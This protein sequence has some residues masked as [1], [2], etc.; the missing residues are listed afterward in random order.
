MAER[1]DTSLKDLEKEI[2]CAIC[3]E[4]YTDPK[5]LSCCHYYCKQCILSL[6]KRTG[7][8]KPFSCPECRKDTALPQGGIDKFQG[9]FFV[10]RL[11]QVH[12]N[13]ELATGEVEANCEI[14]FEDKATAFCRQCA[15]F[16]CAECV[17]SHKRMK[18]IFPDHK[19]TTLEALKEGGAKEIVTPEPTFQT[20]QMHEEM[21]KLFCFDCGCLICRDCTI[22]D[23]HGHNYEF[24][25]KAAPEVKKNLSQ[26]LV[27][28]KE[29]KKDLLSAVK[30]VQTAKFK[31]EATEQSM[32]GGVEKWCDELCQIIQ[33]HKN[34]LIAEVKSN[35]TQKSGRLICQ[36]ERLSI[37]CA[38]SDSVIEFTQHSM[39]HSTDAEIVCVYAELKSR[40]D[41]EIEEHRQKNL[42]P[43]EKDDVALEVGGTE[44]LEKLCQTTAR[45]TFLKPPAQVEPLYDIYM[46]PMQRPAHDNMS[47]GP[48]QQV[49]RLPDNMPTSPVQRV[50]HSP[51]NMPTSPVQRVA[52]SPDN[53][54]TS[55]VQR[56]AHSPDNM[57]T[58]PVQRVAHSPDNMSTSPVQRVAHSP[59]NM[60]TGPVQRV[61][62]SPNIMSTGPVQR[63]AHSPDNMPTSPVQRVAHLPDNMPTG[64]VQR[65]AHSS[66]NMPTSPVQRVAHSSDN[67]PT[68]PVQR[69][70]HSP[71]NMSTG[72]VQRV[73]HL[74]DNMSTGP[75]QRV[76]HLPDN[77][78]TGPVQ[79]VA[80]LPD[81]MPTNPVQRVARLPDNM[82]TNPVQRVAHLPDNMPTSPVQRVAHL[83][84]NMS[85]DPLQQLIH[86]W[87][88]VKK[89]KS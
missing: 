2:T 46:L 78:S 12:S 69:V 42:E 53:M 56:V 55:P 76:A 45:I 8:D 11:K 38:V 50:A 17:K 36:E 65:V 34:G 29:V 22:K 82:P 75:V 23:H 57:S 74:P 54:S 58:G 35:I 61:A 83:P 60:S 28:L 41:K 18:M 47:T 88:Y 68:S 85:T 16:I 3:H 73:A 72:P 30:E 66:D 87:R 33:Q 24:V 21:M 59:D 52:H 32:V 89:R 71:D 4:H 70:A 63:V 20:C 6:A 81:N 79:R 49:A 14:C 43:V 5:V 31:L 26:H 15:K 67:M 84:D 64:P 25:K 13:L 27:P 51:D 62:H 7:L 1:R 86:S 44:E 39:E 10:N 9:A 80:R 40:I 19:I 48:V 77:M 37:S